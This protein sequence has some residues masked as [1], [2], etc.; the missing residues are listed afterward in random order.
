MPVVCGYHPAWIITMAA[1]LFAR[2]TWESNYLVTTTSPGI[3]FPI[4]SIILTAK[5]RTLPSHSQYT[6]HRIYQSR[7]KKTAILKVIFLL[8]YYSLLKKQLSHPMK[9]ITYNDC[10]KQGLGK[11][12][13]I[14]INKYHPINFI[15]GIFF[16]VC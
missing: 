6:M 13:H 9:K 2:Y 5:K 15:V 12:K 16:F 10:F 8:N 4:G 1:F 14:E 3:I 7:I 11:R